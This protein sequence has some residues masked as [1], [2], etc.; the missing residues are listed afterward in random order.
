M[1]ILSEII[2][3]HVYSGVDLYC[4]FIHGIWKMNEYEKRYDLMLLSDS[5]RCL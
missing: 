1:L 4:K 2:K 5:F 3:V